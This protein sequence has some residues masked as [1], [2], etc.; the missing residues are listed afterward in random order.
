ML[1][2]GV[3]Q[4]LPEGSVLAE[5]YELEA[6]L[7]DGAM[8]TV[9]RA[10]HV[11]LG[12]R[13]AVKVL[14]ASLVDNAK[15][16][17]RFTR[18]AELAG[19][20]RHN[21]VA[22]VV[23]VG[24]TD[25]GQHFMAMELAPGI[26]LSVLMEDGPMAESRVLDIAKQLCSG[27][28]HAHE[29]GL[30]H[31]DF[32]PDNVIVE[33][34]AGGREVARIVDWG[35]SILREH[36]DDD[37]NPDRLTTKGI[38]VGT[39]HYMAPEQACADALDHRVDLFALG[40]I[41]YELLTGKLP[42]DGSGVD[43]ARANME[44][45]TPPMAE[46]APDVLVDPVLEEIVRQLLAKNRDERP[47][48]GNAAREL[49]EL[50]ERDRA[51]CARMLGVALDISA[52]PQRS[53]APTPQAAPMPLAAPTP[54]PDEPARTDPERDR[55]TEEV[56]AP[57][58][59]R[60]IAGVAAAFGLGLAAVLWLG[61]CGHPSPPQHTAQV[62][63]PVVATDAGETV[64]VTETTHEVPSVLAPVE[65]PL[66]PGDEQLAPGQAPTAPT[67]KKPLAPKPGT[68]ISA[69]H[70]APPPSAAEVATLY[71]VVGR[72]LKALDAAR[73]MDATLELWPRYRWIRI[74]EWIATPERRA[75][76]AQELTRLRTDIKSRN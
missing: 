23:D 72:E 39:P 70:A 5:R 21:N 62:A 6:R 12:R 50:Y 10:R 20:L 48:S 69:A 9:Y 65:G 73:G 42:F 59:K 66:A 55:A 31:R 36:A 51:T 13:F 61:M 22:S 46:R 63:M 28:Q 40:L 11:R 47:P 18:E 24:I 34:V 35:V 44:S 41:C 30:I 43:I 67:A 4:A 58:R 71:G 15:V 17:Q 37:E 14:H 16:V 7:G 53:V 57:A 1:V 2:G 54:Q 19:R 26:A 3:P 64:A 32:K 45:P 60:R 33:H 27:L 25:G 56:F 29:L 76:I 75:T 52:P 68:P 38:V 49:F 74:N 8:G